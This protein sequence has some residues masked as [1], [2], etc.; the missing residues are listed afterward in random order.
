MAPTIF[1]CE[2]FSIKVNTRDHLPP[3]VHVW[4]DEAE[5]RF[6]VAGG[7][8]GVLSAGGLTDA[9]IR[10]AAEIVYDERE[11]IETELRKIPWHPNI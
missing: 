10:R 8:V 4:K 7:R 11:R 2:G 9:E 5:A 1:R 3:H 6:A